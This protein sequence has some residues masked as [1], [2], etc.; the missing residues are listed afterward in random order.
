MDTAKIEQ[1]AG[2]RTTS[3][4]LWEVLS[5]LPGWDRW[6]PYET[7]VEGTIGFGGPITLTEALPGLPERVVQGRVAEWQPLAQLVWAERRGWM[8]NALHYYEIEE[9]APGNCLIAVGTI[10]SGLRGE[11]FFDKHR[12]ML[13]AAHAEMVAGWK[14]AAEAD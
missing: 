11:W 3:D 2:V 4:R 7:G 13:K 12:K 9:L 1:R 6:N 5:D 10:F 8:F 14:A